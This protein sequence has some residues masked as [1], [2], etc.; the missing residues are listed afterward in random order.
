MIARLALLA[1]LIATPALAQPGPPGEGPPDRGPPGREPPGREQLFISP[2]GEPFRAPRGQPYPVAA[3]FARADADGDGA[4]S[5]AEFVADAL[6]FHA[7]LDTDHDGRLD[8]FEVADYEKNIA[9]EILSP[10]DRGDEG[11][12][13]VMM[14]VG[15]KPFI[16]LPRSVDR[17]AYGRTRNGAGLYGLI[18]EVQPVMGQDADLDRRIDRREAEIAARDR[19]ALLDRDQDGRL[20]L[21]TLPKTPYQTILET[22]PGKDGKRGKPPPR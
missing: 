8:G 12:N 2:S 6:A 5:R 16:G 15:R 3:W 18:N 7:R 9:P 11:P 13:A 17:D 14:D 4:I 22:P 1:A 10:L 20:I 21:A 19:F